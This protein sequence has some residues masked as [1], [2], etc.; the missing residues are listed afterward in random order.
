VLQLQRTIGNAATAQLLQRRFYEKKADGSVVWH[1]EELTDE[2]VDTGEKTS[3]LWMPYPLYAKAP[4]KPTK[5][6][7]K[8][9]KAATPAPA[10]PAPAKPAK[11]KPEPEPA[12]PVAEAPRLPVSQPE[13]DTGGEW[14]ESKSRTKAKQE[15]FAAMPEAQLNTLIDRVDDHRG[16]PSEISVDFNHLFNVLVAKGRLRRAAAPSR[17]YVARAYDFDG[18]FSVE[19]RIP[20]LRNWVIHAHLDPAG[21]VKPEEGA[22]HYKRADRRFDLGCSHPL[23]R[24]QVVA[25]IPPAD[26][27]ASHPRS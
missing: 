27:C 8:K 18:D 23:S 5:K 4:P 3:W 24:R 15:N 17:A 11:P 10:K 6:K 14:T 1:K 22:T 7:E 2:W 25:L 20:D 26:V 16:H 12:K 21:N 9:P 13:P 19:V